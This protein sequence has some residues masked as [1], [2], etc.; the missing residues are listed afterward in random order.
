VERYVTRKLSP[1][2]SDFVIVCCV[3]NVQREKY[4]AG[5]GIQMKKCIRYSMDISDFIC[6][7]LFFSEKRQVAQTCIQRDP[8]KTFKYLLLGETY[9]KKKQPTS[10]QPIGIFR[11]NLSQIDP[12]GNKLHPKVKSM[13]H[14]YMI[15][16]VPS[17]NRS[18]YSIFN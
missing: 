8:K 14:L 16:K 10:D 9:I 17:G 3:S 1:I 18:S 5:S 6:F 15:F 2:A 7:Y 4:D 13:F 12:A 11:I